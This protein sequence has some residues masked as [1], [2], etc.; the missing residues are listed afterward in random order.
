MPTTRVRFL[1]KRTSASQEEIDL[2]SVLNRFMEASEKRNDN[3]DA[4]LRNRQA[5]IVNIET[6]VG[7]LAKLIHECLPSTNLNYTGT[8]SNAQ[9]LVVT[10]E[11]GKNSEP[12]LLLETTI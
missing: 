4:T 12:L 5:S 9:V 3:M 11:N 2:K 10:N 8:N 1:P 6:Q 7:Q